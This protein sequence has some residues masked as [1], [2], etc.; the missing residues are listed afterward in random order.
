MQITPLSFQHSTSIHS[1][2]EAELCISSHWALDTLPSPHSESLLDHKLAK[3]KSSRKS[4]GLPLA[5]RLQS[6]AQASHGIAIHNHFST[7]RQELDLTSPRILFTA[8][9]AG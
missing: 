4:G 7:S 3:S 5:V 9:F 8:S 6:T 1:Q 2:I